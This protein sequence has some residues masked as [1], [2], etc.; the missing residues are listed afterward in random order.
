MASYRNRGFIQ[1]VFRQSLGHHHLASIQDGLL[2][3]PF[4]FFQNMLPA[5]RESTGIFT[6]KCIIK[7]KYKMDARIQIQ[8][9]QMKML[10]TKL[11]HS[12]PQ[13]YYDRLGSFSNLILH[14][15]HRPFS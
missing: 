14:V 15:M 9:R 2:Q 5:L 13:V 7:W 10:F 3:F 6:N 8:L 11:T 12:T 4:I 1:L